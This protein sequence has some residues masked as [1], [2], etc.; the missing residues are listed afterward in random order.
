MVKVSTNGS[1]RAD[2]KK[3]IRRGE[4]QLEHDAGGK[5]QSGSRTGIAGLA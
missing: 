3:E 5:M 1:L 4:K 2:L